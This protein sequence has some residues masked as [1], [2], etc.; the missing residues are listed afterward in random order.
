MSAC[1][2]LT[3]CEKFLAIV[4]LASHKLRE[5]DLMRADLLLRAALAMAQKAPPELARDLT[6]LALC[7]LS[8]LRRRQ[9]RTDESRQLREQAT[10]ALDNHPPSL[11]TALFQLLM[12]SAL[13]HLGE[14]RR[15]IPFIEQSIQVEREGN[16]PV[17]MAE[18]LCEAGECYNRIGLKDHAAAPCGLP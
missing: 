13:R 10:T 7:Y 3:A 15:A 6:P 4:C 2:N 11:Q 8:L 17:A 5:G 12:A 18:L 1:A 9:A 14:Y 16:D